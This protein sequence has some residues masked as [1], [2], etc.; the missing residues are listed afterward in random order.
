MK[1][2]AIV[3]VTIVLTVAVCLI[4]IGCYLGNNPVFH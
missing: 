2:V 3:I 4:G 1:I